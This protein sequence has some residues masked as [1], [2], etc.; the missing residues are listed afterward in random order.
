MA[1]VIAE[2]ALNNLLVEMQGELR[3]LLYLPAINSYFWH[4]EGSLCHKKFNELVNAPYTTPNSLFNTAIL[5]SMR[6]HKGR[7]T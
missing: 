5:Y 1:D 6:S 7:T 3:K 2:A 4:G